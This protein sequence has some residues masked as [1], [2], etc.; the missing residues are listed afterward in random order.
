MERRE[1]LSGECENEVRELIQSEIVKKVSRLYQDL[2]HNIDP[3]EVFGKLVSFKFEQ[4]LIAL[5]QS[6]S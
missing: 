3:D 6:Q 1:S 5:G 2:F 4:P